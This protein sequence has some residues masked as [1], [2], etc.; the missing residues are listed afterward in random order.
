MS[1]FNRELLNEFLSAVKPLLTDEQFNRLIS[2][3]VWRIM[4]ETYTQED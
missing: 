4:N 1:Q 2:E 3:I